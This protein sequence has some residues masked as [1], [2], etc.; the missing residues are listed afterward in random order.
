MSDY[1]VRYTLTIDGVKNFRSIKFVKY[2]DAFSH[3]KYLWSLYWK[4]RSSN[5]KD[6][7][8]WIIV[9]SKTRQ[10]IKID[11]AGIEKISTKTF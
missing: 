10:N 4:N 5:K 6:L 7:M 1:Q 3:V 2:S 11:F 8:T 9:D